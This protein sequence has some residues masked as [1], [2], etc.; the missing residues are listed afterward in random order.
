MKGVD[1]RRS[2]P[3][4]SFFAAYLWVFQRITPYARDVL[5]VC[6]YIEQY[7][8]ASRRVAFNITELGRRRSSLYCPPIR[9]PLGEQ[10]W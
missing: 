8:D 3:S 4:L 10:M 9:N 6:G 5:E 7:I 2:I 1:R